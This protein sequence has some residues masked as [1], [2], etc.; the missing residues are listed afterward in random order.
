MFTRVEGYL[1]MYGF[2][3]KIYWKNVSA[4][5]MDFPGLLGV[6]DMLEDGNT[7]DAAQLQDWFRC[8]S[9]EAATQDEVFQAMLCFLKQY[10]EI[11]FSEEIK[12][13]LDDLVRDP[14]VTEQQW[15][16][17]VQEFEQKS[18]GSSQ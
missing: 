7:A 17:H 8:M 16:A 3:E 2:L 4:Y 18:T 9:H 6:M 5:E 13:V 1:V 11:G 15:K 12:K 10:L 14:E